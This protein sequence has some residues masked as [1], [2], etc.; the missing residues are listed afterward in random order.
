LQFLITI[1][2]VWRPPR[3]FDPPKADDP[4][5]LRAK[6][7]TMMMITD[8]KR[9]AR[10]RCREVIVGRDYLQHPPQPDLFGVSYWYEGN[11][12][13]PPVKIALEDLCRPGTVVFD[14][15]ANMGGLSMLMSRIVG[16]RGVVCSF[17][18]SPRIVGKCQRNLTMNGC[19]NT[20]LYH[21]AVYSKSNQKVPIYL[22]SHLNDSI[23]ANGAGDVEAYHVP[24]IALDD[25]V[26]Y[27]GLTPDVVKMDIEGAEYDALVGMRSTI[28][29]AKPHMVLE[30]QP[31][32]VRCLNFLVGLGYHAIDL[33]TY[34][35]VHTPADYPA[36]VQIR[37]N[38]YIHE[39]RMVSSGYRLPFQIVDAGTIQQQDLET[40]PNGSI[41]TR[42]PVMLPKGRYVIDIDASAEGTDNEMMCGVSVEG[43]VIFRYHAFTALLFK[44]YRDWVIDLNEPSPIS[45]YFDFQRGTRDATLSIRQAK[46]RRV[47]DFDARPPKLFV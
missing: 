47:A 20:Q 14:V 15:G 6:G 39:E 19:H 32:D 35:E 46:I 38:L 42:Q 31:D 18:A 9:W 43:K 16:P 28:E 24:T 10:N 30:T 34:R 8:I 13:E 29:R 17:E 21:A 33:N 1:V 2:A 23:Y 40:L 11:L 45:L 22:G 41:R 5:L 27:T 12:W 7:Q 25:F 4:E 37:N 36:G 26:Q 44:S 3:R